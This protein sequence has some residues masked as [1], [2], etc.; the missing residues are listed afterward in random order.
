MQQPHLQ[1]SA[2]PHPHLQHSAVPH[3]HL[4][5]LLALQQQSGHHLPVLQK[6]SP[7]EVCSLQE[8]EVEGDCQQEEFYN[9]QVPSLQNSPALQDYLQNSPTLQE[10]LQAACPELQ[11]DYPD[12]RD[13]QPRPLSSPQCECPM[14]YH[15]CYNP[16]LVCG[17]PDRDITRPG[18]H[19]NQTSLEQSQ[20]W[21][22]QSTRNGMNLELHNNIYNDRRTSV[23]P[24]WDRGQGLPG[25]GARPGQNQNQIYEYYQTQSASRASLQHQQYRL[26]SISPGLGQCQTY[27][28]ASPHQTLVS[29][30]RRNASPGQVYKSYSRQSSLSPG[31][32]HYQPG[33]ARPDFYRQAGSGSPEQEPSNPSPGPPQLERSSPARDPLPGVQPTSIQVRSE[34]SKHITMLLLQDFK[35]LVLGP[36]PPPD[37]TTTTLRRKGGRFSVIEEEEP[38]LLPAGSLV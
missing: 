22:H 25:P 15:S 14:C 36:A 31:P 5:H 7:A 6:H 38:D 28:R 3:P 4:Q 32:V 11:A 33:P 23:S 1:Y 34:Y 35:Q 18:D 8:F 29:D 17:C 2:L 13:Y 26:S 16:C 24:C 9:D 12:L 27:D 37:Y 10:Y 20:V 19:L 21:Y 30:E